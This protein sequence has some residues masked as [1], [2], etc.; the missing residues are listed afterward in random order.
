MANYEL[1][2]EIEK[3]GRENKIPILLDESLDFITQKQ[4]P[5]AEL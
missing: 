5:A 4:Q 2:S 3:Y 1:L